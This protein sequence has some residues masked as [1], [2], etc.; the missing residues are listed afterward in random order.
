MESQTCT[1]RRSKSFKKIKV[2]DA[3]IV[4]YGIRT[5]ELINKPDSIGTSFY[6]KV[7]GQA[8]FAKGA[9]YVPQSSFPSAVS[10]IDHKRLIK[11]VKDANMNMLRVWGGGIYEADFFYQLC[12]ENGIL[13]WQ[14]FMFANSMYPSDSAFHENIKS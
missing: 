12:D 14:D 9:N 6:F 3:S 13:V 1:W 7:N 4:H 10:A 8:I 2:L 11:Q 5:V